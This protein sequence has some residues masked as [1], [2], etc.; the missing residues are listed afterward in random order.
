M[1][2]HICKTIWLALLESTLNEVSLPAVFGEREE[3]ISSVYLL[4][5]ANCWGFPVGAVGKQS[6]CQ[7]RKPGDSGLIPELGRSPG[8]GNGN[9]PQ[10]SCPGKPQGERSLVGYSHKELGTSVHAHARTQTVSA[11]IST[12]MATCSSL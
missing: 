3:N 11:V 10:Y 5:T 9:P 1:F 7:C 12:Q 8:G 6:A 4:L 2:T